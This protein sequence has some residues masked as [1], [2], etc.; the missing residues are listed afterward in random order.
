MACKNENLDIVSY[1]ISKG[2]DMEG[3]GLPQYYSPLSIAKL[4]NRM[5]I[6]ELLR[7][8]GVVPR[9]LDTNIKG[10]NNCTSP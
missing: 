2:V 5:E 1:L 10:Q 6:C 9:K 7:N 8:A 4:Y 3:K